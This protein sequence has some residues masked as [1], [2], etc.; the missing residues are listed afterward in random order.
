MSA[1]V[2]SSS[3]P[4]SVTSWSLTVWPADSGCLVQF[5]THSL[6]T[7]I[8]Q[9]PGRFWALRPE[10]ES[11]FLAPEFYTNEPQNRSV[12]PGKCWEGHP[13]GGGGP[14]F[15]YAPDGLWAHSE[16]QC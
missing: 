16:Y 2:P 5:N 13:G 14:F 3:G 9:S 4:W 1:S 10:K 15:L 6:N 8:C 11:T 7:N 12:D